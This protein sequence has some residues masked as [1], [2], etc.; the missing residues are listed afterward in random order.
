M[1]L[2]TLRDLLI[3][4]YKGLNESVN[5][6]VNSIDEDGRN[7]EF[8]EYDHPSEL[9]TSRKKWLLDCEVA[10]WDLGAKRSDSKLIRVFVVRK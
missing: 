5:V 7:A 10:Y 6:E 8:E 9:L 1:G 4:A 2:I 3:K